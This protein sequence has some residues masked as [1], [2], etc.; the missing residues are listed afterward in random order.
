M[1]DFSARL[2]SGVT[3]VTWL[4][5]ATVTAPSRINP[6]A[7]I[8]HI[9]LEQSSP[10]IIAKATVAGVE[11]PADTA[12]GGRLFKWSWA[13]L[14]S[15]WAPPALVSSAGHSAEVSITPNPAFYGHCVLLCW[16]K[17]GGAQ[18]LQFMAVA[19]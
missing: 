10:T 19:L 3:P 9:Y 12:L 1:S 16:R 15:G 14:P 5:P 18:L 7:G 11:G 2:T 13:E 17:G 8:P 6:R 4:D